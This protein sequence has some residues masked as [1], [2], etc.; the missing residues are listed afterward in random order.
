LGN[1]TIQ[2]ERKTGIGL[3]FKIPNYVIEELY[4]Q[5]YAYLLQERNEF[6]YKEYDIKETIYQLTLGETSLF[7]LNLLYLKNSLTVISDVL[8]KNISR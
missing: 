5:Y 4:W 7:L 6:E 1:L 2:E 3:T 8:M